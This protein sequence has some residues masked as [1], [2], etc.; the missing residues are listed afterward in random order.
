MKR[1]LLIFC[2][3][4]LFS[5]I[6]LSA[7]LQR[8]YQADDPEYIG[9]VELC[10]L[11]GVPFPQ[12][13][14]APAGILIDALERIPRLPEWA[15]ERRAILLE[16]LGEGAPVYQDDTVG[17]DLDVYGGVDALIH[18]AI[19]NYEF[20]VPYKDIDPMVAVK[21]ETSFSDHAD[22][23][24]EFMEK[25]RLFRLSDPM[26]HYSNTSAVLAFTDSGVSF[27]NGNYMT[28]AYQP[29]LA[30]LSAGNEWFNFQIGRNRQR[31]GAGITGNLV[32]NDNF[33][34]EDYFRLS[35][36]SGVLSYYMDITHFSQQKDPLDFDGFRFSGN[37]QF[38]TIHRLEVTLFDSLVLGVDIGSMFQTDSAFDFRMFMPMMIPHSFNNFS[39]SIDGIPEGDEA[40]NILAFDVLWSFL[41]GWTLHFQAVADQIQLSYEEDNFMPNA[42]GFLL[43]ARNVSYIA[44]GIL[45]SYA[46]IAYTMPYLYLNRKFNGGKPDYN[47]DWIVGNHMT[48]GGEIQYSGYPYGPDSLVVSIGSEYSSSFG[49]D[50]GLSLSFIMHGNH[51]IVFDENTEDMI[52]ENWRELGSVYEYTFSPEISVSYAFLDAH[53]EVGLE[54]AFPY[55]W[56]YRHEAGKG[57]FIPQAFLYFRYSII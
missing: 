25:D 10:I 37:H 21:L 40:N 52:E 7:P 54:A 30:G 14:P 49:L 53:L 57:R 22:L 24:L 50:G 1:A 51:G 38:R 16:T 47:Y 8:L 12:V 15:E 45:D 32:I 46:E 6:L 29:F 36:T 56:N 18:P 3:I 27:F 42:F 33:S 5:G 28:Q 4:L 48:A 23:Y 35:F 17:I 55:K 26:Q 31:F 19:D 9:T 13:A 11:G 43:N 41:P 2:I 44:G 39:E 20:F 34:Y